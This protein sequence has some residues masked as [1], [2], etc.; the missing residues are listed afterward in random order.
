MSVHE[1]GLLLRESAALGSKSCSRGASPP[2][3]VRRA[4]SNRSSA[5]E[6]A[7]E[8]R[9]EAAPELGLELAR[10]E[11]LAAEDAEGRR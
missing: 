11:E 10:R 7:E 4:R 1:S 8:L 3:V 2:G 9:E 5:P 6:A